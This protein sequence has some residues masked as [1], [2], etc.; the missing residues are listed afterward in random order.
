MTHFAR[1]KIIL[2]VLICAF[3]SLLATPNLFTKQDLVHFPSWMPKDKLNLGLDLRGGSHLLLEVDLKSIFRE[4]MSNL[5]QSIRTELRKDRIGYSRIGVS[6]DAASVTIRKPDEKSKNGRDGETNLDRA[7][8][9][10]RRIEQGTTVDS[11]SSGKL[12]IRYTVEALR[13]RRNQALNQSIE[14][15]RRRVDEYGTSEPTIQRQGLDR[16]LVQLPG[17]D[18][19]ERIKRLIGRTAKMTFH[20][21]DDRYPPGG[22]MPSVAPPGT[23]FA[24]LFERESGEGVNY[25]LKKRIMV[26]GDTLVDSQPSYDQGSP[27]VSFRFD[28]VGA[29]KFG[30][31]TKNNVGKPFAIVLDGKIISAP[32]IREPILGGS[33]QI[34]GGFTSD[35][36]TDLS[37]LLRAGALPAPMAILEERTVGPDLGADSVASGEIACLIGFILVLVF[38]ILAYAI[39]GVFANIALLLNMLLIVGV[40]SLLQATLTLPGIAGIVLTVGMAVDANVLIFERIREEVR[41]GRSPLSAVDAGYRRAITT[42]I[43]ANLTTLIAAIILFEFGSGPVRGFAV[44]L[45]V[46]IMTSMFTAIMV[47]RL[48][49]ITWL[50]RRRNQTLPI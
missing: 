34:S 43:D 32:V 30:N 40:L 20:L 18:D 25:L 38:M 12:T 31:V 21:V 17:V 22:P 50:R 6:G 28:S 8:K 5:V 10:I 41:G 1:W 49:I 45:A 39:F 15:V 13:E 46:G 2:I 26:G 19:P 36:V 33:G 11:E 14:I 48:I 29:R 42:I 9:I 47:T 3:G 35:E 7:R 23:F 37:L 44:T 24:K 16:I 27:V 4:R